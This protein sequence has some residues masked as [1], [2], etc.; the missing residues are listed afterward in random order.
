MTTASRNHALHAEFRF[1]AQLNDF[2]E[3]AK[4]GRPVDYYFQKFP[5]IKDPIEALGVPHTEVAL[6][7][8]NGSSVGFDYQLRD[9]DRVAVYPQFFHLDIAPLTHLRAPLPRAA[10]V[11]D[12]H[13]GKLARLLRLLGIDALYSNSYDDPE[14]VD[15]AEG[16]TRVL[17]T[18]DRRLLF[19]RRV[20]YGHFVRA[21][22][23]LQQ[24]REVINHYELA[25][26]VRPFSRCMRCNGAV[27]SVNKG[28]V[29]NQLQP[30]TAQ[31]YD[32]FYRC[33]NCGQI[34]WKGPHFQGLLEVINDLRP[35]HR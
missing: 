23:P 3:P 25:S 2:L 18:R 20:V 24:A 21:T 8:V 12:V 13:L 16:E 27:V 30:K 7:V 5:G 22:D 29:V 11:L 6:I 4:R 9:G 31:Y 26:L 15:I 10:F 28:D 17:L 19:H 14:L 32:E 1:Y 33:C 34:Y 35:E